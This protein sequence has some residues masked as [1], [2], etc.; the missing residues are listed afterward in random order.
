MDTLLSPIGW[1]LQIR[2]LQESN[3]IEVVVAPIQNCT[4]DPEDLL[5]A[6]LPRGG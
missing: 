1:E 3:Q 4:T 2:S 5:Q 6:S